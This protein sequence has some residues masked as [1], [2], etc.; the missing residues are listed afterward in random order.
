MIA[1]S[2]SQLPLFPTRA[3]LSWRS[4][5]IQSV[6]TLVPPQDHDKFR[7]RYFANEKE[8]DLEQSRCRQGCIRLTGRGRDLV[9]GRFTS[10]MMM[11]DDLEWPVLGS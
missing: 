8:E 3:P 11:T 7:G 2:K 1:S 5:V 9:F 10:R 6:S 4:K